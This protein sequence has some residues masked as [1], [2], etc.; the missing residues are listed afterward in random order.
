LAALTGCVLKKL[1]REV[2]VCNDIVNDIEVILE[3]GLP[4]DRLHQL[5]A[6]PQ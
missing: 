4:G 1:T 5:V 2:S 6:T 3:N